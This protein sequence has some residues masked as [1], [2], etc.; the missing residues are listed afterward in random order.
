MNVLLIG[1]GG[2]LGT[3]TAQELLRLGHKV[4]VLCPEEKISEDDRLTFHRGCATRSELERLFSGNKYHGIV[5]FVHYPN[6]QE[7]MEIHPL[8]AQNCE[9]LIFLSSYR[10]YA[11]EQHPITEDAPLLAHVTG[12]ADFLENEKYA[13]SKTKCEDFLKSSGTHNWTVV[14]PVISFSDRRLDIVVRSGREVLDFVRRGEAMTLPAPAKNLTA[15]LDWAGNSGKLIANLLFKSAALENAY[16][17]SSAQN[18]TWGQVAEIYERLTGVEIKWIPTE[19]FIQAYDKVKADP[20]ILKY[21]RFFDRCIDNSKILRDAQLSRSD[22]ASVE[23]GIKF[24][25]EKIGQ[26]ET[27]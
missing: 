12:D 21:D 18:L 4:D 6:A 1:G 25:L 19:E 24:E 5:N 8:L 14:R 27:K 26:E 13:V 10:A 7:Y 23:D 15:A 22:F 17:V 9:H 2:T 11:D 16:T 20:W 3:Y